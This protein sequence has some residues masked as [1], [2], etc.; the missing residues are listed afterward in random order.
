M[1][2]ANTDVSLGH[3]WVHSCT[4]M[5]PYPYPHKKMCT[6]ITYIHTYTHRH[7]KGK[8]W[9]FSWAMLAQWVN[10]ARASYFQAKRPHGYL[11]AYKSGAHNYPD[12]GTEVWQGRI[13]EPAESGQSTAGKQSAVDVRLR[14]GVNS[15]YLTQLREVSMITSFKAHLTMCDWLFSRPFSPIGSN[16]NW[17]WSH[18]LCWM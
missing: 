8:K 7:T 6:Y 5:H 18:P 1:I 4:N 12:Q 2:K 16:E 9:Q 17:G 11:P 3:A 10:T 13:S 15:L 14:W